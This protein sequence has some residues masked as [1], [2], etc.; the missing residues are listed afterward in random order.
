MNRSLTLAEVASGQ[1]D[2]SKAIT[3]KPRE[4]S[5]HRM[6]SNRYEPRG[7]KMTEIAILRLV[8]MPKNQSIQE[9]SGS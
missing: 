2:C 8:V 6:S 9:H 5:Q 3:D 4:R 7:N 1:F